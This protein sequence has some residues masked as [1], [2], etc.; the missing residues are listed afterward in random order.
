MYLTILGRAKY[1]KVNGSIDENL[2]LK[3]FIKIGLILLKAH[4]F[5]AFL[6]K[7]VLFLSL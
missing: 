5:Y 6:W 1:S 2:N 3:K 4:Y 7:S